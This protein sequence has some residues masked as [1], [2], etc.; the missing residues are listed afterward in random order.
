MSKCFAQF[1]CCPPDKAIYRGFL[2]AGSLFG[3][4]YLNLGFSDE[5]LRFLSNYCFPVQSFLKYYEIMSEISGNRITVI[6]HRLFQN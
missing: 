1:V 5:P 6:E 2:L 3:Q 4:D